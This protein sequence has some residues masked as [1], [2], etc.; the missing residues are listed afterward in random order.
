V[1][2]AAHYEHCDLLLPV[3][4]WSKSLVR[5]G[6]QA[7]STKR[8]PSIRRSWASFPVAR[9]TRR[10]H[11]YY[12]SVTASPKIGL[13]HKKENSSP[14]G[15]ETMRMRCLLVLFLL[16]S[17][18]LGPSGTARSQQSSSTVVRQVVRKTDPRY[19]EIARRMNISGTVKVI[20]VVTPDG[21]VKSLEAAGGHPLL[22]QAAEEAITHWRFAP[23]PGESRESI[24]L[25]FSL[26]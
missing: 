23:A 8:W 5:R 13:I 24:E 2:L 20:A 21:K 18:C 6:F 7:Q 12:P 14:E 9:G 22:I 4:V 19:P 10:Y 25:H 11:G 17:Y 26:H 3:A 1:Q 15:R 16:F